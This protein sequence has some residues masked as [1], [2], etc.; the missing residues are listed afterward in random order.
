M[1][2]STSCAGIC[3]LRNYSGLR[4]SHGLYTNY[5]T[6]CEEGDKRLRYGQSPL[7][8]SECSEE[9]ANGWAVRVTRAGSVTMYH[10]VPC[11]KAEAHGNVASQTSDRE[12]WTAVPILYINGHI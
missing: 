5:C 9:Y 11:S 7:A 12:E 2:K 1:S 6:P 10:Y 8:M 3:K 4:P